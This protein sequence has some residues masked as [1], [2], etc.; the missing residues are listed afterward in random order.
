MKLKEAI[1]AIYPLSDAA[2]DELKQYLVPFIVDKGGQIVTQG[3]VSRDVYIVLEGTLRCYTLV[4][5]MEYTRWFA[6]PGDVVTSMFSF[7]HNLPASST[8]AALSN[9]HGYSLRME[10][11]R[12]LLSDNSEW[13]QWGVKYLMEGL[14]IL[15]RRQTLLGY[16]DAQN[17][18]LNLLRS[19]SAV[20]LNNIP[21]QHVASYLGMTP[22]TLS[23]I[24]R[25]IALDPSLCNG[26]E[27]PETDL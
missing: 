22:Q 5:G 24:R 27:F 11:A 7:C 23:R 18:Y 13:A 16:G 17:R 12:K 14:F 25:K 1:R 19:R 26:E 3:V 6:T 10:D 20:T 15:E 4:D 9:S 8:I 2:I 21:L